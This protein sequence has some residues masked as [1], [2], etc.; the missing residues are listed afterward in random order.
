[1]SF[2]S[3]SILHYLP[4]SLMKGQLQ[5]SGSCQKHTSIKLRPYSN[6]K[7]GKENDKGI[8]ISLWDSMLFKDVPK[9]CWNI[10]YASQSNTAP[11]HPKGRPSC[12]SYTLE[13]MD[14][15]CP[16][17]W[18]STQLPK[19]GMSFFSNLD[20]FLPPRANSLFFLESFLSPVCYFNPGL[21]V[22]MSQCKPSEIFSCAPRSHP[23]FSLVISW[24]S[25]AHSDL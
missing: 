2:T 23:F 22:R 19:E 8:I 12:G 16:Y 5:G 7:N 11:H 25:S 10:A 24:L 18:V 15:L 17:H 6:Q 21:Y 9:H 14:S 20:A 1:M 4:A 13:N 3:G